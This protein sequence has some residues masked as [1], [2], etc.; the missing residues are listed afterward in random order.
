MSITV[1]YIPLLSLN[2]PEAAQLYSV[3]PRMF[4]VG[5]LCTRS[6]RS[7]CFSSCEASR[8][9]AY[10]ASME[11]T[12]RIRSGAVHV[13]KECKAK[14]GQAGDSG[15]NGKD[16]EPDRLGHVSLSRVHSL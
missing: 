10:S 13:Q 15:R 4:Y 5:G 3:K 16:R 7:R 6:S 8:L 12:N 14:K 11:P 9:K 1:S 2:L